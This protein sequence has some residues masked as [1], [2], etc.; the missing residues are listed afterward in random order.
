MTSRR[1]RVGPRVTADQEIC[2]FLVRQLFQ[3][4][5][6]PRIIAQ[7]LADRVLGPGDD[8]GASGPHRCAREARLQLVGLEG[9]PQIPIVSG[10]GLYDRDTRAGNE[11]DGVLASA[12]VGEHREPQGAKGRERG[13]GIRVMLRSDQ[14]PDVHH[15]SVDTGDEKRNSVDP[16]E[17]GDLDQRGPIELR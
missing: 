12:P 15:D 6:V 9:A 3:S 5:H 4:L 13:H 17:V 1:L 7:R 10:I 16:C 11:A 14:S 2:A 8:V